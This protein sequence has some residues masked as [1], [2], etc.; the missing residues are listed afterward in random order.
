MTLPKI[1]NG[2]VLYININLA[3]F[4]SEVGCKAGDAKKALYI[5]VKDMKK[6]LN[7]IFVL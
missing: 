1:R 6:N 2:F 7:I 5:S 3:N 4:N